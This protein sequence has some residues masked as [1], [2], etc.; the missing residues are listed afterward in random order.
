MLRYIDNLPPQSCISTFWRLIIWLNKNERSDQKYDSIENSMSLSQS[1]NKWNTNNR[2]PLNKD[3]GILIGD[4]HVRGCGYN[5]SL[6]LSKYYELYSLVKP[7]S[8]SIECKDSPNK[9]ISQMSNSISIVICSGTS[10]YELN[11]IS[12]TQ[13]NITSFTMPN[14]HN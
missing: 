14:K 7:G 2:A 1:I 9:E 12:L 5:S 10:D 4:S 3:R 11:G 6:L 8:R 13:Q